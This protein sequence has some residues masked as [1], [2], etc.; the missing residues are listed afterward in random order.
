MLNVLLESKAPR[1]RRVGGTLASTLVHAALVSGAIALTVPKPGGATAGPTPPVIPPIYIPIKPRPEPRPPTSSRTR[2]ES[3]TSVAPPAPGPVLEFHG[4]NVPLIRDIVPT[5]TM[6]TSEEFGP[7]IKS[8]GPIGAPPGLGSPGGVVDEHLVD[9]APR[10]IGTPVQPSFPSALRQS[11]RGGRVLV[12][13]V[14]DTT[15]RAEM[16]G[17]TVM[18]TTDP[19][20]A[21][22]VRNVLP[23][24]R[25]SPGEAGGRR[26]RTMV[27]L[28]FD[29]TL[30]R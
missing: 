6:S 15:G 29:F 12:Q 30:L 26:V 2:P 25:F 3:P 20:F 10:L 9:R 7:G 16:D 13:F 11:G 18:E 4:P 22:S 1:T 23:R 19:L 5:T 17:F 8:N 27:Q 28:P 21:E 14:V 24:Y